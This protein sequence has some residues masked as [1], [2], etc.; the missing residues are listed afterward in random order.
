[1]H[2]WFN[3]T[4]AMKKMLKV[5]TIRFLSLLVMC[6]YFDQ[7]SGV[8]LG[9]V[10]D[11]IKKSFGRT[12]LLIAGKGEA[13]E[14]DDE[15]EPEQPE[16]KESR[17]TAWALMKA[18]QNG[19]ILSWA[20]FACTD[21]KRPCKLCVTAFEPLMSWHGDCQVKMQDADKGALW[22]LDDLSCNGISMINGTMAP[23]EQA[24]KLGE[25]GFN[26]DKL[27]IDGAFDDTCM[28]HPCV[29]VENTTMW[30]NNAHCRPNFDHCEL[31]RIQ[32]QDANMPKNMP[33]TKCKANAETKHANMRRRKNTDKH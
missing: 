26:F 19:L 17:E 20:F 24:F 4:Y 30:Y 21:R 16:S 14:P 25:A 8:K 13:D 18:A 1:M 10:T 15:M 11:N 7:F 31:S 32:T 2:R 12:H 29:V 9:F 23:L 6:I 5:W 33:T 27:K 28:Q 22:M 3:V